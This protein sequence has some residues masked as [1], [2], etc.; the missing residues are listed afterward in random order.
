MTNPATLISNPWAAFALRVAFG[1]YIAYLAREFY[2]DPFA[3]FRK[4]MPRTAD[5]ELRL[6]W[7]GPIIRY[8]A[9]FCLWG[10]CFI[11]A[12]AIAVQIF[13]LHGMLLAVA[14]VL[15]AAAGAWLLLPKQRTAENSQE[16]AGGPKNEDQS[17]V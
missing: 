1:A 10:G 17:N 9:C 6:A 13:G 16:P 15:V 3:Y 8:L 2:A 5:P 7:L 12:T 11:V 14:L 4:V